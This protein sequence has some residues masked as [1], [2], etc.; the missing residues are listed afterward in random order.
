MEYIIKPVVSRFETKDAI[1]C[2]TLC[3]DY[4]SGMCVIDCPSLFCGGD[5]QF[6]SPPDV[7]G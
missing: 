6:Q 4:C 5:I 2:P 1:F 3:P 7:D